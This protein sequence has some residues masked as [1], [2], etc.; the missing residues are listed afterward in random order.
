MS[1]PNIGKFLEL[2]DLKRDFSDEELKVAYRDL[3]QVWHPDKYAGNERLKNRAEA[4][5]K[6]INE[7]YRELQKVLARKAPLNGRPGTV[8]K[9]EPDVTVKGFIKNIFHATDFTES[10]EV[11]FVHA[12]KLSIAAGARLDLFHVSGKDGGSVVFEFPKIR[13]TLRRWK[14]IPENSTRED[15]MRNLGFFYQKIVGF[16]KDPV[17]SILQ[18]LSQHPADIIVLAAHQ[19]SGAGRLLHKSVSEKVSRSSGGMTLFL[20]DEN[21]G[22]VSREDGKVN[23]KNILIPIDVVPDPLISVYAAFK[24]A[25][26]LECSEC[27]FT[28]LYVGE[29]SRMPT[30]RLPAHG[31][32][33]W[34]NVRV[35]NGNVP[36]RIMQAAD[37]YSSDLIVMATQGE[38][39]FLDALRGNTTEKILRESG[40]PLLSVPER[41]RRFR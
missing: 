28:L 31:T 20:K 11:A 38:R 16:H 18:Y 8:P 27:R 17:S 6:E 25:R 35:D 22:F 14:L 15:D 37:K 40:C 21:E 13:D 23:L 33:E 34:N 2:F 32:W 19:R 7:A 26:L 12:L 1:R 10:S 4:K 3:V 41:R 24:F 29:A 36:E 9:K 5:I 30:L 39:G